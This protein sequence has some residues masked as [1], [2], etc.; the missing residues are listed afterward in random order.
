MRKII[1]PPSDIRHRLALRALKNLN[2]P[3]K[4]VRRALRELTG[5]SQTEIARRIGAPVQTVASNISGF[6]ANAKI[7]AAIARA[8]HVPKKELFD[9]RK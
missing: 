3:M 2:Y 8:W 6:R 7:Q 9:G 4:N 5:T 1:Q